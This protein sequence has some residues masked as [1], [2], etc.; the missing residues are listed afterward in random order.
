ML[1][2]GRPESST[3]NNDYT[4]RSFNTTPTDTSLAA[5]AVESPCPDRPHSRSPYP[6]AASLSDGPT[7]GFRY[8]GPSDRTRNARRL[9]SFPEG[10]TTPRSPQPPPYRSSRTFPSRTPG[11]APPDVVAHP[12]RGRPS[13]SA[14]EA[15]HASPAER[16]GIRV[17]IAARGSWQQQHPD[18]EH[19]RR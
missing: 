14:F 13:G 1:F 7:T 16:L 10:R 18:S 5:V 17:R 3:V 4:R 6:P 15:D 8:H 19:G 12:V 11:P 2:R 9:G